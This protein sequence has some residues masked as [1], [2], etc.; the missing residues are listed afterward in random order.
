M[1]VKMKLGKSEVECQASEKQTMLNR[2]YTEVISKPIKESKTD[3][4]E[5]GKNGKA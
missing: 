1:L 2:G 5:G 3:L 4:K